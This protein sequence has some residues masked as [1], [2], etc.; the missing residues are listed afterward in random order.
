MCKHGAYM[1]YGACMGVCN[2]V[3]RISHW[4]GYYP[5]GIVW[6]EAAEVVKVG[7]Q[8]CDSLGFLEGQ[9][10]ITDV[11]IYIIACEDIDTTV[12]LTSMPFELLGSA[13]FNSETSV[14]ELDW[15]TSSYDS[16]GGYLIMANYLDP[17]LEGGE[18]FGMGLA[19]MPPQRVPI[20]S[21]WA[22]PI[23]LILIILSGITMY[24]IRS[25]N[26]LRE[27]S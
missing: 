3:G 14:W 24:Y 23:L 25:R 27:C 19:M 7:F 11:D 2:T 6:P 1:D 15:N 4:L 5:P 8:R 9:G 22:L 17:E 13:V 10:P 20:L 21:K 18:G 12:D 16:P 26:R